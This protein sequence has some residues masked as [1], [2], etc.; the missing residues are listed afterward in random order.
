MGLNISVYSNSDTYDCT[1][2]GVTS[3]YDQLCVVNVE[4][5]D[6]PSATAPAVN[7]V[8]GNLPGIAKIVP[9][10][11]GKKWVMFGGNY[12]ATSDSRFTQAVE[13]ITGNPHSGAV[14]VH[15]RV[16]G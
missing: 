9:E 2:N 5:P 12:A 3:R 6:S 15:D 10:E 1:L 4:G 13:K 14:P 16:E 8:K 7:L 11:A